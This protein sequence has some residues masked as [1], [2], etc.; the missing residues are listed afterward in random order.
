M[1]Y[2][3][4]Y[5]GHV[6]IDFGTDDNRPESPD[7][8]RSSRA[9]GPT[10]YQPDPSA[11]CNAQSVAVGHYEWWDYYNGS[12]TYPWSSDRDFIVTSW[13]PGSRMTCA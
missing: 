5:A 3:W 12:G 9:S 2:R 10:E 1:T 4:T 7:T 11:T 8:V 6:L 13:V